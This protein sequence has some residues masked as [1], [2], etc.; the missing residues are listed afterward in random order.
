M[1]HYVFDR[2]ERGRNRFVGSWQESECRLIDLPWSAAALRQVLKWGA[3]PDQAPYTHQEIAFW[4]DRLHMAHLDT[5]DGPEMEKVVRIAA[6]V[7]CQWDLFL[8]NTYPLTELKQL[9]FST[10]QLPAQWF[11]GWLLE[12]DSA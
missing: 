10:V 5:D 4:C 6:D 2:D 9:D 7:D 12:L 3:T 8:A 11:E 1:S